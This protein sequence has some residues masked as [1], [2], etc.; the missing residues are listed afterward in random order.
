FA[1]S[2]NDDATPIL[3]NL[4]FVDNAVL[5][6]ESYVRRVVEYYRS[7]GDDRGWLRQARVGGARR[8]YAAPV[9]QGDT[10]FDTD[11]WRLST[12]GLLQATGDNDEV[13]GFRMDGR[14]EGA[15]QPP[16]Y[17]VVES[18]LVNLQS[19]ERLLGRPLGLVR[20]GYSPTYVRHGFDTSLNP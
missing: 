18:A 6:S 5:S 12:R 10:S 20:V 1:W 19:I 2:V 11:S 4:L 8:E 15:D 13:E 17:P 14:M 3:S 16:F 7:I 9:T